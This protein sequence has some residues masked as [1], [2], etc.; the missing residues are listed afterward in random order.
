MSI[1]KSKKGGKFIGKV[2]FLLQEFHSA[3][4]SILLRFVNTYTTF[5]YGSS[6]WDL[7]SLECQT[8]YTAWNVTV[9][10]ILRLEKK[11][12]RFLIEPLSQSLHMIT[13]LLSRFAR[14]YNCLHNSKKMTVRFLTKMNGSD[15]RTTLGKTLHQLLQEWSS[16]ILERKNLKSQDFQIKRLMTYS[17]MCVHLNNLIFV[18]S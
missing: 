14:F 12:H 3:T 18:P 16:C 8:I 6:C 15:K 1:N 9:M 13:M 7:F 17:I 11:T 2:N 5:M 10:Q 4:P